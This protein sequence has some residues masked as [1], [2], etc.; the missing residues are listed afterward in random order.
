MFRSFQK[1]KFGIASSKYQLGVNMRLFKL[2]T[3]R[4]VRPGLDECVHS[5]SRVGSAVATS[6]NSCLKASVGGQLGTVRGSAVLT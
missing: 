1:L 5:C 4:C 2:V 3:L 6:Y